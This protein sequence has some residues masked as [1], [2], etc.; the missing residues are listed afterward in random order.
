MGIGLTPKVFGK[1]AFALGTECHGQSI[2]QRQIDGLNPYCSEIVGS[3]YAGR[4]SSSAT[5]ME[6]SVEHQKF[7][8]RLT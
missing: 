8:F 4:S 1:E 5:M 7:E 6:K 3:V 2:K